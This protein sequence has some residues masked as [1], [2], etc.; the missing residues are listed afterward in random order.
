MRKTIF[1]IMAM[2]GLIW[3][4]GSKTPTD[5]STWSDRKIDK[6]Y[7]KKEWLYGWEVKPD[8]SINKRALAV[9]YFKNIERWEKAFTFIKNTDLSKLT[10]GRYDIDG[11][12][13]YASVMEY[14]TKNDDAANFEAHRKYVDIQYMISGKE[15]M[16]IA[17]LETVTEVLIPYDAVKDIEFMKVKNIAE[18]KA[19]STNFFLFFPGDA[20]RPG[21]KDGDNEAIRKIVIKVRID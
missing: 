16:N 5:P 11:D 15:I 10:S 6:W 20:H 17:P 14:T 12:N 21:M 18:Y 4:T 2:T 9:S 1:I 8:A 19:D 13:L 7:S 3:L